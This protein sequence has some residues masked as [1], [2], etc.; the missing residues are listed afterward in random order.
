VKYFAPFTLDLAART[1]RRDQARVPLTHKALDLLGVLVSRAGHVVSRDALLRAVWPDTHVHPDNVKVLVGEI[2]RALGDDP[3]RPRFIRS[4]VKR[5]YIFIAP[6]V[7]AALEGAGK[8]D[9]I[10]VGR[11]LEM[12]RLLAAL[13]EA[14]AG[15]RQVVFVSGEAGIGK[16]ALCESFLRIA[17][18]RHPM[19]TGWAQC[20]KFSGS[21][22][23][24]SPL[25]DLLTRLA[26]SAGDDAVTTALARH[27]PSWLPHLPG[28]SD[29]PFRSRAIG[30]PMATAARMLREIVTALE[31]LSEQSTLVLWI[32][33]LH[34]ADA[35]T[36]DV[37]TSLSQ[38][39]DAARILLLA[40]LRPADS[41]GAA[42]LRRAQVD[43]IGRPQTSLVKLEPL[44][45]DDVTRYLDLKLGPEVSRRAAWILFRL[46]NG[47]PLFLATAIGHLVRK[48]HVFER[49]GGWHVDLAPDALEAAIPAS[50]VGT[51]A[52]G[53]DELAPDERQA[54]DGASV[55]GV[56]FSLWL[57]AH[58]ADVDELALEPVLEM[59]ARRRTFIVR[60][61]VVELAN[62]VFSP[63]YRFTHG[64]YQEIVL[65]QM[66]ASARADAHARAGQAMERLFTGRE[67]EAAGDLACHFHGAG[68]HRRAVSYLRL[69]AGNAL[70]RYAPREAA[71]LL[72]GAVTHASHLEPP[73]RAPVELPLL[74]ELGQAQ[75]ASGEAALAIQTLTKLARRAGEERQYE[76]QLRALV[77]LV[78]AHI[79]TSRTATLE[80]ARQIEAVAPLAN[81]RVL[82]STAVIHAGLV[83]LHFDGWSDAIADR[84][85]DAWRE[86]PRQASNEHRSLAIRLLFLQTAR[87]AYANAWTA[88][89][90]LLP[91]TLASGDVSDC[92]YVHYLLAV[93][94]LHL[95]RWDDAQTAAA[96]GSAI[97][98]RTGSTRFAMTMRL[99]QAWI[100]LEQQRFEDA[101]RL[102]IADRSTLAS[103]GWANAQQMSLLFGGASALGLGRLDEAAAD[104]EQLRDW[105][106]RERVL[107]DWF[108][109]AHLHNY[110][111]ELSLRR[112]DIERATIEAAA[113]LEAAR[114]TP[115]RTWRSRAHVTA[116][117]VA[118]ERR[119]F[120]EAAQYLRQARLEVRGIEAPL[121]T[122]RIEAVTAT[123]L[124]RT[125]QHDSARRA[126]QKYERARRRLEQPQDSPRQ[127]VGPHPPGPRPH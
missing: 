60:E 125:A 66:P 106:A 73:E 84:C 63:L 77:S 107:M 100:A 29:D 102:S 103:S 24:Y 81:D 23:P 110:L 114:A 109:E 27:A 8:N 75:L 13:D 83:E 93:S 72:H 59:L 126:R 10:F 82:S 55:V 11:S 16:T 108:W 28:L 57:A 112:G 111:A 105:H 30:V 4:L 90:K 53:L 31:S 69:A 1:L 86:L 32:E 7:D 74:L 14:A 43:L 22:E 44:G 46:T 12:N 113:A 89:R 38:R 33:D 35:A 26:R 67:H 85:L 119:A 87:S 92:V 120:D 76:D 41:A 50:L 19:R 118:L 80:C 65:E 71:A 21:S 70:K 123:L 61:G 36:I 117:L 37:L 91:A 17:A 45:V 58:A 51:V 116:A 115:E 52:R 127:P 20:M 99:L 5:G 101:H 79:G 18:S 96:E 25:I 40:T 121:V 64:L 54:I 68:D 42:T 2:R 48:G 9:P 122:W 124:E 6:V 98:E 3:A 78:E 95:A 56:E 15:H 47:N 94:A 39:R 34:W 88:G 62:G 49:D 104:L 97:C